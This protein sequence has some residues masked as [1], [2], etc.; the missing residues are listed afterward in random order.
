MNASEVT[1][2]E[3]FEFEEA[4]YSAIS[5]ESLLPENEMTSCL[6]LASGRLREEDLIFSIFYQGIDGL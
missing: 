4:R 6:P 3:G 2:R 1:D 5:R